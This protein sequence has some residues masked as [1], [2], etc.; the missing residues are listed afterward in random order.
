MLVEKFGIHL[1]PT[2]RRAGQD[3]VVKKVVDAKW[4]LVERALLSAVWA[5]PDSVPVIC[6]SCP[7]SARFAIDVAAASA[8]HLKRPLV[9][10]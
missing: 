8:D 7:V 4:S 6:S 5:S 1:S 3:G 10:Y 2:G 9:A